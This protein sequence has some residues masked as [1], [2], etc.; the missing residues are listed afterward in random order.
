[1]ALLR[2]STITPT[3]ASADRLG[4]VDLYRLLLRLVLAV[5]MFFYQA[6]SQTTQAWGFVWEKREWPLMQ[7]IEE[8]AL[9][10]P[11]VTAI[12]LIFI[13]L[14][15]P[16]G[17]AVGF[18]TRVNAALTLLATGFFFISGLP[19]SDWLSGQTYL[20]FMGVCAVLVLSGPGAF[21][22]DGVFFFLRRRRQM[23]KASSL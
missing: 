3:E 8:M 15:C 1:M 21:S 9:P 6:M 2:P 13:L 18:L 17:V 16:I 14:F 19:L 4:M 7:A 20:L 5:P 11:S 10:Q 12:S 22:I 23:R